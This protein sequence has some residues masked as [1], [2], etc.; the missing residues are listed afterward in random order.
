MATLKSE[1]LSRI[2]TK[3]REASKKK[4]GITNQQRVDDAAEAF[5]MAMEGGSFIHMK[6]MLDREEGRV[7]TRVANAD[8]TPI[9]MYMG[10]PVDGDQAP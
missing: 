3:L 4:E 10:M 9:K 6:E 7:A 5:V 1:L 2:Q 8:G